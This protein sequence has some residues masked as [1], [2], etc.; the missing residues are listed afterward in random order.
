[1]TV[2][3]K[4][5]EQVKFLTGATR[6]KEPMSRNLHLYV[7]PREDPRKTTRESFSAAER[8]KAHDSFPARGPLSLSLDV[9]ERKRLLSQILKGKDTIMKALRKRWGKN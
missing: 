2:G 3:K 7:V 9:G 5:R 6:K 4:R 1:V 8:L